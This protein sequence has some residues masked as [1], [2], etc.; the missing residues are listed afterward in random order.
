MNR[1]EALA[2][3][4]GVVAS[5]AIPLDL[6]TASAAIPLNLL[7][8]KAPIIKQFFFCEPTISG[9]WINV[10]KWHPFEGRYGKK[11]FSRIGTGYINREFA[12]YFTHVDSG[13]FLLDEPL[14][15]EMVLRERY[16]ENTHK[17]EDVD[18]KCH[19]LCFLDGF[20]NEI[21]IIERTKNTKL[22]PKIGWENFNLDLWPLNYKECE[23]CR[24]KAHVFGHTNDKPYGFYCFDCHKQLRK[25]S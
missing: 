18:C 14:W 17:C 8:A 5:A 16:V 10:E 24:A 9:H 21:R 19:N 1:R 23:L 7:T 12:G 6:L 11:G 4:S 2:T 25:E 13:R 20:S 15:G 22:A 3:M